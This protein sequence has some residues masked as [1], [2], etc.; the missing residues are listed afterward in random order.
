MFKKFIVVLAL[1]VGFVIM[2]YQIFQP[3]KVAKVTTTP[4]NDIATT[5]DNASISNKANEKKQ[6]ET[7][8]PS[9]MQTEVVKG[10]LQQR[11]QLLTQL[12]EIE[13]CENNGLCSTNE[14]DPKQAMFE[15]EALF[16]KTL[17]QLQ[18]M[19]QTKQVFDT[20][21]TETI[22]KYLAS[23]LG[24]VQ[25]QAIDMFAQQPQD[26]SNA[27]ILINALSDSYDSKVM[28]KAMSVLTHY[29][30]QQEQYENMLLKTLT[31]GSFYVSRTVAKEVRHILNA[32]NITKFEALAATL[33]EKTAKAKILKTS[34]D[35][36]KRDKSN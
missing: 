34:I 14:Q 3:E 5:L 33:P 27:E 28:A 19:H 17:K 7:Q 8:A 21:Y 9:V 32:Q 1:V 30:K 4:D 2:Y 36:Y 11:Q 10:F 18:E 35:D 13:D 12:D 6:E 31:T 22:G 25:L 15:Q 26:E 16:V 29:P 20:T 23:S 24:R